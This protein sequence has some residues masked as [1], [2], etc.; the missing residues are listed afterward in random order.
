MILKKKA[1]MKDFGLKLLF[2]YFSVYQGMDLVSLPL[3][4]YIVTDGLLQINLEWNGKCSNFAPLK[5]ILFGE[6][7][8]IFISN[9]V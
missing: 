5:R 1:H 8:G 4:N 3:Q 7:Y 2:Q 9:P 6:L